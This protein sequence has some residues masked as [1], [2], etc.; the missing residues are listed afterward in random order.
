[1]RLTLECIVRE[2]LTDMGRPLGCIEYNSGGIVP[3]LVTLDILLSSLLIDDQESTQPTFAPRGTPDAQ[4]LGLQ[5]MPS[6][7][8]VC[9]ADRR[10]V[11]RRYELQKRKVPTS[12]PCTTK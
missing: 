6:L 1:M 10:T 3:I 8:G 12:S 9:T 4:H 2:H 11:Y 7:K 5:T